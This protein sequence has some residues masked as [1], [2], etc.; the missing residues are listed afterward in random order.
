M[1]HGPLPHLPVAVV[2][3]P[4]VS[5]QPTV[6]PIPV[7]VTPVQDMVTVP[8]MV[9][10]SVRIDSQQNMGDVQVCTICG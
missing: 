10:G 8:T 1:H 6:V 5:A 4:A 9:H 3:G 2:P 7:P